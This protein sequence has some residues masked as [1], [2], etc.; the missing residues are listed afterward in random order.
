L[1]DVGLV[2]ANWDLNGYSTAAELGRAIEA[3]PMIT[4]GGNDISGAMGTLRSQ[5]LSFGYRGYN[6]WIQKVALTFTDQRSRDPQQLE[7]VFQ[8]RVPPA[9]VRRK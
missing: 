6:N 1:S 2:T 8:V 5:T 4:T 7:T 9:V 3:L